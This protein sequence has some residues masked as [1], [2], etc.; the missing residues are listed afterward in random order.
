LLKTRKR[1]EE[2]PIKE[3][4][5]EAYGSLFDR[6]LLQKSVGIGKTLLIVKSVLAGLGLDLSARQPQ[7]EFS[8]R[9]VGRPGEAKKRSAGLLHECISMECKESVARALL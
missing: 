8:R 6:R 9:I 7:Y 3:R 2:Q 5:R 1:T 4:A